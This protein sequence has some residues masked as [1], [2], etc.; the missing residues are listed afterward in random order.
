MPQ[1]TLYVIRDE[2]TGQYYQDGDHYSYR[3][4]TFEQAHVFPTQ[5]SVRYAFTARKNRFKSC[6]P[7]IERPDNVLN[8]TATFLR[9]RR[10][11]EHFG[12]SIRDFLLV[13]GE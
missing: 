3:L 10:T 8:H 6:I 9:D 11:L 7:A 5:R 4:G 13:D 1:R 2:L 12:M